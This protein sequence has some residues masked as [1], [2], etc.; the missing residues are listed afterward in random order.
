MI[1]DRKLV[2]IRHSEPWRAKVLFVDWLLGNR[3]NYACSYCPKSLHDG[4]RPWMQQNVLLAFASR[5]IELCAEED[6]Q[7]YFQL[8]GGEVTLIPE[9]P[10][11]LSS[12]ASLGG[13]VGLISNGN[14]QLSWW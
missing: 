6:R 7:A 2:N 12:I 10:R 11:L 4:S 1:H 5:I 14:R 8:I 9:L 3:C 13:R